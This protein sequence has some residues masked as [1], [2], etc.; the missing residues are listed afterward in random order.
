M[1]TVAEYIIMTLPCIWVAMLL[2]GWRDAERDRQNRAR[3][4]PP[5]GRPPQTPPET[6]PR[7]QWIW[8]MWP[9]LVLVNLVGILI[10]WPLL[11]LA[12][13]RRPRLGT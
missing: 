9:F 12:Y 6:K 7:S 2:L 8:L 10:F 3:V 5:K 11:V 4:D 13:F 1:E